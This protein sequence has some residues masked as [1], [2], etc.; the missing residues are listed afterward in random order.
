MLYYWYDSVTR[1]I[2]CFYL[3]GGSKG[4]MEPAFER[5]SLTR[6]TLIEQSNRDEQ[7][8]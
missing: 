2:E 4:S 3:R 1:G 7:S 6:D 5:A 8:Q